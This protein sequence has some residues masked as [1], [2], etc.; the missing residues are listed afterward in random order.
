MKLR[1]CTKLIRSKNAG[2]FV[3]TI[4]VMFNNPE[5]F[6]KCLGQNILSADNVAK[7]YGITS[8][9][10]NTFAIP[11]ISTIKISFPRVVSQGDF[12]DSDNHGGQQ[13]APL[14]DLEIIDDS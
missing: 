13:Y 5:I 11:V 9:K 10:I 7:V 1:D 4:D 3:L 12:G 14:L 2:P 8:E 6:N